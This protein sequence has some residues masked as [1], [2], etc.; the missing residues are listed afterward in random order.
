MRSIL[1]TVQMPQQNQQHQSSK[2]FNWASTECFKLKVLYEAHNITIK[3]QLPYP[4]KQY[5]HLT[6]EG[7][8][9]VRVDRMIYHQTN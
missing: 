5:V 7:H 6:L 2:L 8:G 1:A 9:S 3:L 4:N